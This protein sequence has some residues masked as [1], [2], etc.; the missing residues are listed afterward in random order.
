MCRAS[1]QE[2]SL[3]L[4]SAHAASC[5]PT[6]WWDE[7]CGQVSSA[8]RTHLPGCGP[9]RGWGS[10]HL[11]LRPPGL[12]IQGP[13]LPGP[14]RSTPAPWVEGIPKLRPGNHHASYECDWIVKWTG[15]A[16]FG[17]LAVVVQGGRWNFHL[18]KDYKTL[19]PGFVW[20]KTWNFWNS[21]WR[22][23][24]NKKCLRLAKMFCLAHI[25]PLSWTVVK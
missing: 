16:K 3:V 4:R 6:A 20:N 2:P 8:P 7:T 15:L 23:I 1:T 25:I 24:K 12:D 10:L 13:R 11:T 21:P 9:S 22:K 19:K 17:W 18:A 5:V 14:V